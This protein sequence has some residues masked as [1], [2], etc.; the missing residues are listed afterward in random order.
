MK[1]K[2]G[3]KCYRYGT[4]IN[5]LVE[6]SLQCE[7]G[8]VCG[9]SVGDD[10]SKYKCLKSYTK[11]ESI[12]HCDSNSDCGYDANCECNDA[13]GFKVCVPIPSSSKKLQNLYFKFEEDKDNLDAAIDYYDYLM[14]NHLY[15]HAEYRCQGYLKEFSAASSIKASTLVT[16]VLAFLALF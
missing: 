15:I 3:E 14:E 12:R 13:I 7:E 6:A 16:I 8:L 11:I 2:E 1:I 9:Y 5:S 10:Q 4:D